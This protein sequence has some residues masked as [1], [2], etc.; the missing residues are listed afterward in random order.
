MERELREREREE[1]LKEPLTAV[2]A[3]ERVAGG[4][5]AVPVWYLYRDGELRVVTGKNSLKVSNALRT[6][7]ATLCIQR[8]RGTDLRYLTVE[9]S[10][11]VAPCSQG[12]R[13]DLWAHYTDEKKAAAMAAADLSGLCVIILA[14]QRWTAS[15]E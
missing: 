9:G 13:R 7:R 12:E 2:L 4:V 15:S 6:G 3:T 11:R 14:P 5:H 1:L 8:S 10:V